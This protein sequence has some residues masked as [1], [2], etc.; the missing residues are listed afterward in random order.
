MNKQMI[1]HILNSITLNNRNLRIWSHLLKKSLIEN[2]IFYAVCVPN[3]SLTW[4]K[5]YHL[6]QMRLLECY[7]SAEN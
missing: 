2:F 4:S 3:V 7:D 5:I 6:P 1:I